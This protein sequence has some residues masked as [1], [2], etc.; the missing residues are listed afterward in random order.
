MP[1]YLTTTSSWQSERPSRRVSPTLQQTIPTYY[2]SS[3]TSAFDRQSRMYS[4][5]RLSIGAG[6][7]SLQSKLQDPPILANKILN[8]L[9]HQLLRI[10]RRWRLRRP[11]LLR[12]PE[13]IRDQL[14]GHAAYRPAVPAVLP[15]AAKWAIS[16]LLFDIRGSRCPWTRS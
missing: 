8:H 4:K 7:I 1:A 15:Q 5:R 2:D 14:H 10:R 3:A 6:S 9:L 11:I 16:D 12:N 13:P